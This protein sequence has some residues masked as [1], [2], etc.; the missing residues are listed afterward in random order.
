MTTEELQIVR[1][2]RALVEAI[3]RHD[4]HSASGKV[5]TTTMPGNLDDAALAWLVGRERAAIRP[6]QDHEFSLLGQ[7]CSVDGVAIPPAGK[8]LPLAWLILSAHQY[9]LGTVRA[10]W[11]FPSNSSRCAKQALSRAATAVEPYCDSLAN[12]IRRI[13]TRRGELIYLSR[14][15]IGIR[16][17]LPVG[18]TS[19]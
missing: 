12:A 16:C 2:L 4:P 8:G 6:A 3:Q 10:E 5:L 11:V 7:S 19:A 1:A 18:V 13:G 17:T 14:A 15:A 9:Q